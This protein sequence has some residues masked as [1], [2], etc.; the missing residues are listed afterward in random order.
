MVN[1]SRPLPGLLLIGGTSE[2]A[3]SIAVA[4]AQRGPL[5]VVL[6]AR[7]SARRDDAC[8]ILTGLGCVVEPI[9]FEATDL[10]RSIPLLNDVFTRRT[11]DV[12]V[13]AQGILPDQHRLEAEPLSA[14]QLCAVNYTSAVV[15]GLLLADRMRAQ[16]SGVIVAIS[17]A[18]GIRPRVENY[19]YGSTKAGLDA[20]YTGLRDRLRG[21]G[22]R[23]L[24]VRP[25]HVYTRMTRGLPAA[26]MAVTPARVA[27]AVLNKLAHGNQPVW[28]PAI[29]GPAM[30][31][32]RILPGPLFRRLA[33]AVSQH[34]L[35]NHQAGLT[36]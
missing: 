30:A 26:P 19:L 20:F 29:L 18:G 28:V 7:P 10:D 12:A 33:A 23:V 34:P 2:I 6:A 22:V 27:T 25:G 13:V 11:V 15:V 3:G 4:M 5:S 31:G 24:V 16:K 32:L 36:P 35:R 9:D 8:A 17:S 14:A 21:S 1:S